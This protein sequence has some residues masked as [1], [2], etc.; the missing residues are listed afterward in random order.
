MTS[1]PETGVAFP[2]LSCPVLP[3]AFTFNFFMRNPLAVCME[4]RGEQKERTAK[5][6]FSPSSFFLSAVCVHA[7]G[8]VCYPL[9]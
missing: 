6:H 2:L 1:L 7:R 3:P 5:R 4:W 9:G 8:L